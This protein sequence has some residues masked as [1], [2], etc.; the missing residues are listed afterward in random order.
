LVEIFIERINDVQPILNFM[1]HSCFE[2]A[3]EV[4]F[5]HFFFVE[6]ELEFRFHS[7]EAKQVDRLIEATNDCEL[8]AITKPLL[9]VPFSCNH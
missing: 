2:E 4:T 9:G 3:L 5:H 7:K 6:N 1:T 8:F